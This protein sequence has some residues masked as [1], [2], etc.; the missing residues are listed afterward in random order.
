MCSDPDLQPVGLGG[1]VKKVEVVEE[2]VEDDDDYEDYEK[3]YWE[4]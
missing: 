2:V 3:F 4:P 1:E